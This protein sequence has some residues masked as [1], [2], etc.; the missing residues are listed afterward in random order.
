M[1]ASLS[2]HTV[3]I[4]NIVQKAIDSMQVTVVTLYKDKVK[5]V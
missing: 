4:Y 5:Y 2:K 1:E 3:P